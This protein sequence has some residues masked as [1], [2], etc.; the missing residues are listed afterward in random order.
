M[1]P[2]SAG[3]Q[4]S[5]SSQHTPGRS[6]EGAELGGRDETRLTRHEQTDSGAGDLLAQALARENMAA[7]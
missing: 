1:L 6:G 4:K 3:Q 2:G 5:G 7:A